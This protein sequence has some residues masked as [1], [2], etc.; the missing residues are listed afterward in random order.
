MTD[1]SGDSA[2][3]AEGQKYGETKM[4]S[5]LDTIPFHGNDILTVQVSGSPHVVLKPV[6]DMLGADFSTQLRKLKA[7]SWGKTFVVTMTMQVPGDSQARQ[8]VVVPVRTLLML[9]AT[10]DEKR[11]SA[12]A[13]E[14]LIAYQAEVADV[15]EA[16]YTQG[17]AINP[18]ATG[19]QLISLAQR[20][21]AQ[22]RVLSALAGIVEPNWLEAKAR[23]VAAR[24][25]GEEPEIDPN[26]RPLTVSEYLADKGMPEYQIR[27][28]A[29]PFGKVLK[30]TYI[31]RR[32]KQPKTVERFVGGA[33]R[34]VAGYTEADRGLFDQVYRSRAYTA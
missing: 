14:L 6:I 11:V 1:R 16:Y 10:I 4:I 13:R 18:R 24:A 7:K 25:L 23:H 9:L 3:R 15:I 33:L 5:Q 27:S 29:S 34:Q 2:N 19:D 8:H 30:A 32:G 21:E 22:A 17:G 31:Q 20:A 26:S 12:T 28:F